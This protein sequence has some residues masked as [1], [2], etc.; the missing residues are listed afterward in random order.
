MTLADEVDA[1]LRRAQE[2]WAPMANLHEGYAILL[3]E[4][5]EF[6]DH[7]KTNEKRRDNPAIRKELIQIAA[8]ALRAIHDVI[9]P[10][11]RGERETS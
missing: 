6:W 10:T 3:E 1:E 11:L 5:D 8:M 4:V 9:D 7:V 2:L